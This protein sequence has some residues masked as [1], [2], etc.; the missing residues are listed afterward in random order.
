MLRILKWIHKPAVMAPVRFKIYTKT[1]DKGTT[2]LY[3]G[4][5]LPKT[6]FYFHALG[7]VDELNSNIGHAIAHCKQEKIPEAQIKQ[8]KEIQSRL[9]DIGAHVATPRDSST[10]SKKLKS[11]E[12]SDKHIENLESWIDDMTAKLPPLKGFVLPSGGMAATS[13]HVSRSVCRR[14]ERLMTKL[15]EEGKIDP[16][17]YQYMN[18]LSD[19]L[20]T[21]ARFAAKTTGNVEEEWQKSTH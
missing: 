3:T 7:T 21:L 12:F 9:F 13:V 4:Q 5:R 20:F 11:T 6:A 16:A 8:M 14:C 18:R 1:G 15:Y 19:Y 17:V 10:E 2:A